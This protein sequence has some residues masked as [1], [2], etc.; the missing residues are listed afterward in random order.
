MKS[1][2]MTHHRRR[3]YIAI[4]RVPM[5]ALL[6][7]VSLAFIGPILWMLSGSLK[8]T[9]EILRYPPTVLPENV[10]WSNYVQVFLA[11]PYFLQFLNSVTVMAGVCAITLLLSIPA[12][13]ALSKVRPWGGS[14]IFLLLLS[15]IFI[16]PEATI[17]PLYRMADGLGWLDTLTPVVVFTAVLTTAPIATFLMRQ[18]FLV[19]PAEFQEA[20][21]LDG[22]GRL[23]TML[24]VYLPLTRPSIAA[25]V[26]LSCW[27]SWNQFLEPLVYLRSQQHLTV[28]VALTRYLDYNGEPSWGIQMAATT[29]SL[30]PVLLVFVFAQRHVVAGL[31]AGG[32]KS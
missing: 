31:T 8:S 6:C 10:Q 15:G 25:A 22:A 30:L 17:I 19:L 27:Y 21:T 18:A 3:R 1:E 13:Y 5:Y 20:A 11:Q 9:N 32:L 12:G 26:V 4:R 29:L 24:Q 7:L 2:A 23:R 14:A 28:S 16:P